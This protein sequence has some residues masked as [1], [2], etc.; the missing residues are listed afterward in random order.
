MSE[1]L[2]SF[3]LYDFNFQTSSLNDFRYYS[4]SLELTLS[5]D[6]GNMKL[7]LSFDWVHSF[8]LTDEGDLLK[9]QDEQQGNMLKGIYLVENS[10]YL[11]WFNEQSADVH[12]N[13]GITHYLIV[14]TNDVVDALSSEKPSS[15]LI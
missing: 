8:R 7:K 12:I 3:P 13:E 5:N 10:S 15:S 9:M 6:D 14:T 1:R 11:K 4:G 2:I